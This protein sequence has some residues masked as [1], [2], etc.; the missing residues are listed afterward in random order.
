M[1]G[2]V[3]SNLVSFRILAQFNRLLELQPNHIAALNE[4]AA[5]LGT[6]KQYDA[7][8]VG[9]EK[10]I[11]LDPRYAEAHLNK[12][13]LCSQVKR[14]GDAAAAYEKR[15]RCGRTWSMLGLG[16]AILLCAAALRRRLVLLR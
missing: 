12:A 15:W 2:V 6:L 3:F 13:I 5:V 8:L 16:T 14:Y 4:R 9:V 11:A 10:A 7:A 1:G